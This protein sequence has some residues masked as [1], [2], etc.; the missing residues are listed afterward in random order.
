MVRLVEREGLDGDDKVSDRRLILHSIYFDSQMTLAQ[1]R[2]V[3][4]SLSC[5]YPILQVRSLAPWPTCALLR[6]R[7]ACT[8]TRSAGEQACSAQELTDTTA[9]C[10]RT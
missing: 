5:E 7:T 9:T 4:L 6:A 3:P 1:G 2:K 10:P 8:R